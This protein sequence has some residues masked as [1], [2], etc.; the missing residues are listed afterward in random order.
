MT[1]RAGFICAGNW[2]V[3][4]IH[5]VERWPNESEL[6]RIGLQTRSMGGGAANV[7]SALAKLKT[8]LPLYPMG[9]IGDDEHGAF[10]LS[11]CAA[12]GLPVAGL[13][14][15]P[16]VATAHTHV[17]SVAGQSRTFFYQGG[18]NDVLSIDDFPLGTFAESKARIFYLGYLTLLGTLD[19]ATSDG[20]TNAARVLERASKA[21]L[22]TCVDLVSMPHHRF[23]EIVA[24]AAPF[25]DYL[26]TNELEAALA[27][28]ADLSTE[29]DVMSEMA[30]ALLRLGLR[31][32]AIVHSAECAVWVGQDG[33]EHVVEADVLPQETI[34]S[35][36]GAGDAFCAGLL[37]GVHE[38]MAPERSIALAMA[39][40]RASLK[41]LAATSAIPAIEEILPI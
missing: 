5:E 37:Y 31:K 41:G 12:L 35:T 7:I 14:T 11:E 4:L 10:I 1:D 18:A 19:K 33:V 21:G 8:G 23:P 34:A 32:S 2:I 15:K 24:S 22:I 39:V 27:L 28:G 20:P 38:S 13:T 25:L 3:D 40:A 36:L 17:M 29:P 30:H 9:A 16:D 6:T 26:V